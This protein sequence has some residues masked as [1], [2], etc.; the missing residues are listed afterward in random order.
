MTKHYI[1]IIDTASLEM[2]GECPRNI[3]LLDD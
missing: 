1:G 2:S 3:D